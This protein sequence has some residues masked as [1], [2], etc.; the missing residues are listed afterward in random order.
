MADP[1]LGSKSHPHAANGPN[2]SDHKHGDDDANELRT[3]A[4]IK[5]FVDAALRQ[6]APRFS[7]TKVR[8]ATVGEA[9][10]IEPEVE[11]RPGYMASFEPII[12]R[13]GRQ[14]AEFEGRKL[15]FPCVW[16]DGDRAGPLPVDVDALLTHWGLANVLKLRGDGLNESFLVEVRQTLQAMGLDPTTSTVDDVRHFFRMRL[17]DQ[18][19][20]QVVPKGDRKLTAS[21]S[22]SNN[23][24][25]TAP[26]GAVGLP[27]TVITET[28][29][30]RIHVSTAVFFNPNT[31]FGGPSS[32]VKGFLSPGRYVFGG[33]RTN[34]E[35]GFD[36]GEF[37][38]PA[39]REARLAL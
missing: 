26:N 7:K 5:Y 12:E 15:P 35:G 25:G 33:Y 24:T 36:R 9:V 38:V 27:F 21:A 8:S 23:S 39:L 13:F 1:E 31:V 17:I 6:S 2:K 4:E 32:P 19:E 20:M 10:P 28:P 16:T 14:C 37:P 11:D 29:G 30:L 18:L 34:G 3:L 22:S